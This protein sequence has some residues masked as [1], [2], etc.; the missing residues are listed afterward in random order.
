[1]P[2]LSTEFEQQDGPVEMI[3][4]LADAWLVRGTDGTI[5]WITQLGGSVSPPKMSRILGS[6]KRD[7][8]PLA[9]G[10]LY[11]PY[12]LGGTTKAGIDCSGFSQRVYRDALGAVIP[13]HSTDQLQWSGA[14][15]KGVANN[16]G[17]LVFTQTSL[18]GPSHVGIFVRS[19]TGEATVVHASRSRGHVVED[20]FNEYLATASRVAIVP[21]EQMTERYMGM[22]DRATIFSG[23][24]W[25]EKLDIRTC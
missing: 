25:V 3:T 16:S 15:T 1:M 5:G 2:R 21:I 24:E 13:R 18:E 11:T 8:V 20:D 17:D 12:L 23:A 4:R 19:G 10:Y 22:V 6:G 14:S 7:L 9:R